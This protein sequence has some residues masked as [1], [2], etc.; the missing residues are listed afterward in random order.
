MSLS[1]SGRAY[2][3][4]ME[5]RSFERGETAP[6]PW[7]AHCAIRRASMEPRSFERG[8]W[9]RLYKSR[10]NASGFNGATFF[11]TW[12]VTTAEIAEYERE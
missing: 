5:P 7:R 11:R 9:S 6:G 1:T 2:L 12:R 3:A 4:S 8:E 10:I